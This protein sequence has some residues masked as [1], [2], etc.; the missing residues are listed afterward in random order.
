[1]SVDRLKE[2]FKRPNTIA[3]FAGVILTLAFAPIHFFLAVPIAFSIFYFLLESETQKQSKTFWQREVFLLGFFFGFGHFV[4]GIYWICI[5]LLI[6]VKQFGWLVPFA[7]TIIPAILAAYFA[8]VALFYKYFVKRF[9]F[10]LYYEKILL[11]AVLFVFGEIA[12]SNFLSGFS[13]NLLGYTWMFDLHFAQLGSVFGT[14]GLSFFA[15]LVGLM[16]IIFWKRKPVFS[17]KIFAAFVVFFLIA[18]F[19]FGI[20]YID[21]KKLTILPDTVIRLVQANVKQEIKWVN[22]QKREN[23]LKHIYMSNAKNFDK[24]KVVI[25]SETSVPY[26]VNNDEAL[27]EYLRQAV[28]D[29]GIL[30]TGGLRMEAPETQTQKFPQVWNSV[31]V[32]G[33]SGVTQSYDKHHLVPFGEFVPFYHFLS[34]MYLDEA[35]DSITGGGQG[36]AQ[37]DG[38]KTLLTENFSFSPL[39]CYE[40]IFS[41]EVA[42]RKKLPELFINLTNDAWFGNSSGPYQHFD[43]ARMRAIEYGIPL[44]RVAGS[45]ISALVDPFGRVIAKIPL[46]QE[47]V[48]DV[49]LIKN[50]ETSLY[51]IYGYVPLSILLFI[52][53]LIL[54]V[55]PRRHAHKKNHSH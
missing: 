39:I 51:A 7:L 30:I 47:G 9:G 25:W 20:F 3:F 13:W 10:N 42:N 26:V 19:V 4:S 18:N 14:Y 2:F 50:N 38:A 16:P 27:L 37:G 49:D 28:P 12:R 23:L 1:M 52:T 32:L 48:M 54:I 43:M 22:S 45:G 29:N 53:L 15:V 41:S 40:V 34:F 8:A 33:K 55:S 5:S 6:D 31:F 46:N 44:I 11:F 21:N 17:D 36:F 35:I 24:V